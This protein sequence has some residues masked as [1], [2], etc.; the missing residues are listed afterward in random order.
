MKYYKDYCVG[1]LEDANEIANELNIKENV[2]AR[3]YKIVM[4]NDIEHP[5]YVVTVNN[6]PTYTDDRDVYFIKELKAK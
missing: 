1:T 2:S 3:I 6:E 4:H 5:D